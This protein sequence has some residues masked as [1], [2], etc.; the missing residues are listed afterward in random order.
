MDARGWSLA[1]PRV[2]SAAEAKVLD[3]IEVLNHWLNSAAFGHPAGDMPTSDTSRLRPDRR[4]FF[5]TT[6][7]SIAA[8]AS[9]YRRAYLRPTAFVSAPRTTFAR[10]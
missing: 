9:V 7:V 5:G 4:W 8:L 2:A 10:R 1:S 6:T 3:R